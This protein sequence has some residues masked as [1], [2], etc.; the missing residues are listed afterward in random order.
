MVEERRGFSVLHLMIFAAI[1]LAVLALSVHLLRFK[2]AANENTARESL[3]VYNQAL[4][5]YLN[6][7][8]TYPK[9]LANLGAG[10]QVGVASADLIDPVLATGKKSGYVFAYVPGKLDFDGTTSAYTI[11][12]MP[13]VAG[14]TGHLRFTMDETG[15]VLVVPSGTV[16]ARSANP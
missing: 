5:A 12:A 2:M 1:F 9:A 11:T 6:T 13:S 10:P 7:Y 3:H 16:A 14:V 15:T 8:E 4:F